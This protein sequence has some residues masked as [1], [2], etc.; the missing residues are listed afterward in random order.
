MISVVIPTLDAATTL[1]RTLA[2]LVPAAVDGLVREVVV[3]DGGST[4]ET[5]ELAEDAGARIVSTQRGR[6][7]QLVAGCA[8]ARGPWLLVLHADTELA[9]GWAQA[10]AD[11]I[12]RRSDKAGYFRFALDDGGVRARL[13]ERGVALRCRTMALPYGDQGLLISKALYDAVGGYRPLPLMEDVD[14]A[15]RLK[16][17]L[18]P[19]AAKAVTCAERYRRDGYLGRSVKNAVLVARYLAGADPER[20]ARAYG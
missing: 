13:W 7:A 10:A 11:H 9:D 4:D 12:A 20:L 5:L 16:G 3:A 6:G 8:A 17:R 1:Q 2:P 19:L 14:L 18:A 15:R